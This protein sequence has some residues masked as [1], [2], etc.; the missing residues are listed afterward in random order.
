MLTQPCLLFLLTAVSKSYIVCSFCLSL[1]P[2][3]LNDFRIWTTPLKQITHVYL[4]TA[5]QFQIRSSLWS[6][7]SD[8]PSF[9]FYCQFRFQGFW[10][11]KSTY[12]PDF[13]SEVLFSTPVCSFT[14]LCSHTWSNSSCTSPLQVF[15][16][17]LSSPSSILSFLFFVQ[18]YAVLLLIS[19]I[20]LLSLA[21]INLDPF[22]SFF[23]FLFSF[24]RYYIHPYLVFSVS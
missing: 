1:F 11:N 24:C 13:F 4:F 21:L 16:Q 12:S 9:I 2:S 15:Q 14:S 6:Y 5:K 10:R 17:F 22:P 8:M 7:F 18:S 23:F 19:L 20:S 3:S